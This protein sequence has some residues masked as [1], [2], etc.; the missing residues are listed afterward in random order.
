MS[1]N[2]RLGV[3]LTAG[4]VGALLIY[5]VVSG[6]VNDSLAQGSGFPH[7]E[8]LRWRTQSARWWGGTLLITLVTL[9]AACGALSATQ[10]LHGVPRTLAA[11]SV[12]ALAPLIALLA[13]VSWVN[14]SYIRGPEGG[15]LGCMLPA[16]S[17]IFSSFI[18]ALVIPGVFLH[19]ARRKPRGA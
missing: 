10:R 15:W 14:V 19:L 16:R 5:A 11:G 6:A 18:A 7:A 2:V 4:T 3:V 12:G 9:G 17:M 1:A 13:T 8:I